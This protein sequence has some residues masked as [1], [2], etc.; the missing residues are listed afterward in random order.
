MEPAV[1][2]RPSSPPLTGSNLDLLDPMGSSGQP[3]L[4]LT[5][6]L[7]PAKTGNDDMRTFSC[8]YVADSPRTSPS[9]SA[10]PPLPAPRQWVVSLSLC[11]SQCREQVT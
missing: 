9:L 1:L 3:D 5:W 2:F 6:F 4:R 11:L 8:Y 7:S 10:P